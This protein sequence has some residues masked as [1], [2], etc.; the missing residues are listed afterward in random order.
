VDVYEI[1]RMQIPLLIANIS[2]GSVLIPL[3]WIVFTLQYRDSKMKLLFY[4]LIA[5]FGSDL[6]GYILFNLSL[7][8]YPIINFFLLIQFLICFKLLT[9]DWP[10]IL[11]RSVW[12][13]FPIIFFVNYF[14]IQKPTV[15]NSYSNSVACLI[16]MVGSLYYFYTLLRDLPSENVMR[17]PLFWIAIGVLTYYAG[18][19]LLFIINNYLTLGAQGSHA[20]MWIMH[21]LLNVSKN[22][23]FTIAIWQSY[24][25][26]K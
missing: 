10:S 6:I 20:T 1:H 24:R 2:S 3:F 18:N 15:F 19:L 11:K 13:G 16:L 22:I 8:S 9:E 7:N 17:I 5:S 26:K 23:I 12:I 25:S 21:N 4:L 14:L